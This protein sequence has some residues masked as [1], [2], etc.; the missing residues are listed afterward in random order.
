M[1]DDG[2]HSP[3]WARTRRR[4]GANPLGGVIGALLGGVGVLAAGLGGLK[5]SPLAAAWRNLQ[6]RHALGYWGPGA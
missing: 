3:V 2:E 1:A 4:R 6:I 5:P